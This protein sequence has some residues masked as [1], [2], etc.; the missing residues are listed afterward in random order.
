[1]KFLT[2]TLIS[3][4]TLI[5]TKVAGYTFTHITTKNSDLSY[6]GITTIMQD[7]RGFIWIGTFKGLNRYDGY[8]MKAY[9]KEDMGLNSDFVHVLTEDSE[10]NIWI[11]T[12]N[13]ISI[14]NYSKDSF[15][16]MDLLSDQGTTIHNKVT[17]I[18]VDSDGTVRMLVND[19]GCF[20]Y[21]SKENK[22]KNT[23]YKHLGMSGFRRM[24][25]CPDGDFYI[26]RYH[27]DLYHADSTLTDVKP[28]RMSCPPRKTILRTTK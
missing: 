13:G 12:D 23:T 11:G 17:F 3:L 7:S 15:E 19:Q 16:R 22:L 2:I 26:S 18:S 25:K 8:S 14:Y 9:F 27:A 28:V 20:S 10:G 21:S 24:L 6:D 5:P 1:M 4:M